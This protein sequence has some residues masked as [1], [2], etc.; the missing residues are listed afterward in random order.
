L[1]AAVL[2]RH[3]ER[4]MSQCLASLIFS[5]ATGPIST[6]AGAAGSEDV[7]AVSARRASIEVFMECI[8]GSGAA[9]FRESVE[10]PNRK[11]VKYPFVFLG[12]RTRL[13]FR[14]L[15]ETGLF[16]CGGARFQEGWRRAD[17]EKARRDH[18][19]A[20]ERA[21]RPVLAASFPARDPICGRRAAGRGC[22]AGP[23]WR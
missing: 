7:T 16:D 22:A 8:W 13:S 20:A 9:G 10:K 12:E 11:W 19:A 3:I 18:S 23:P 1:G 4:E 6:M 15:D 17:M 14:A 21:I 5:I 2:D